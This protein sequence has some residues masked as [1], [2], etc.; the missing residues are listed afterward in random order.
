MLNWFRK[1]TPS[2]RTA[3]LLGS[4][5][6]VQQILHGVLPGAHLQK[7][8][9]RM[10]NALAGNKPIKALSETEGWKQI[11]ADLVQRAVPKLRG[12]CDLILQGKW[13]EAYADASYIKFANQILGLVNETLLES[14]LCSNLINS[15]ISVQARLEEHEQTRQR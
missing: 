9:D 11:E 7:E 13:D 8:I 14:S 2:S 10:Q 3:E 1:S 6:R 15:Y 5:S 12:L 4:R